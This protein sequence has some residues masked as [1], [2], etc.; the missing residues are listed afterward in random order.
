MIGSDS[1]STERGR[2]RTW[3]LAVIAVVIVG[4]ALHATGAFMVPV[5]FSVFLALLVAPLDSKVSARVPGKLSWLGHVAAMGAILVALLAFV[6]LIWVAAQQIVER[7]PVSENGGSLLPQF[8][9]ELR[10]GSGGSSASSAGPAAES[11]SGNGGSTASEGQSSAA[12]G[13]A[14]R[15]RQVVS[16][17][18]GSLVER[19]RDWASGMATQV[20]STAGTTLFATVLVFFLTL[21]MLVEGPRWRQKI[22]CLLEAPARR[23]AMHAV[24]MIAGLLRRYLMARTILGILTAV[25]YVAWLWIFGV[26]LLF[27]WALLAFLLNYVPTIGSLIAGGLP[28]I[29]AFVQKDF[30][31]AIAVGAGILVIEQVMGNYVDP[32]VQGRQVSLSSLVVLIT[33][34]VWGWIWG[35]AGAILAVPI[36]IAAMIICAYVDPLRPFALMLSNTVNMEDL[37]E[38]AGRSDH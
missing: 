18:G 9:N 2:T 15:L 26:D 11:I 12:Q 16:G 36:T 35:I 5:V 17:A 38:Q 21:I 29:Y 6:G 31:T 28:V 30:G 23:K 10:G 1:S 37:D 7:F 14:D 25:L 34:L 27:V 13:M 22:V 20:L 3:L 33:L 4:W 32:R 24:D 19:F 8:G